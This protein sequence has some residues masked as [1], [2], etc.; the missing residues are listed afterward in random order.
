MKMPAS[1]AGIF[2]EINYRLKNIFIR[3]RMIIKAIK[4]SKTL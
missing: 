1:L 4:T 3:N 2:Y